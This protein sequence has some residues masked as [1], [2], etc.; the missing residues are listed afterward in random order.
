[1]AIHLEINHQVQVQV[2]AIR[3]IVENRTHNKI[4]THIEEQLK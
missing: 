2:Q 3:I 1:V 4:H